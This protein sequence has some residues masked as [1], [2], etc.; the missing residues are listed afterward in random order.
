MAK[1]KGSNCFEPFLGLKTAQ[2]NGAQKAL[3]FFLFCSVATKI[4]KIFGLVW[5]AE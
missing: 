2:K 5:F 3:F 4:Y 1:K